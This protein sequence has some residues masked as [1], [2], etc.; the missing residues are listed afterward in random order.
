MGGGPGLL[1][2]GLAALLL[3]FDP[4]IVHGVDDSDG[5]GDG[6]GA[7]SVVAASAVDATKSREVEVVCADFEDGWLQELPAVQRALDEAVRL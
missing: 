7:A 6:G 2:V 4:R 1:G 3:F 5:D